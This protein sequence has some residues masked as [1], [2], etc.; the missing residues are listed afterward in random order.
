MSRVRFHTSLQGYAPASQSNYD[1]LS[2][3]EAV[4]YAYGCVVYSETVIRP[5]PI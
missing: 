5:L 1:G 3:G 2:C 4:R